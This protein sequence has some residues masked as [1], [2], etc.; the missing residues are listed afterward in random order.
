MVKGNNK[1]RKRKSVS[2]LYVSV[3]RHKDL[4]PVSV[5]VS[6]LPGAGYIQH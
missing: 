3:Q 6:A 2:K 1:G 4:G 5:R